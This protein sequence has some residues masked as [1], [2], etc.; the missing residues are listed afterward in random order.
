MYQWLIIGAVCYLVVYV[1][2]AIALYTIAKRE[3]YKNKWMA[4]VPVFNTYYIGVCA[5]KNKIFGAQTK[6]ISLACAIL[7]LLLISG[8][9]LNTV[10]YSLVF[11]QY[12]ADYATLKE[13]GAISYYIYED[14][15]HIPENLTWAGWICLNFENYV[16]SFM[17]LA[18]F[19]LEV[20]VVSSFFRTYGPRHYFLYTVTSILFPVLGIMMFV[21]RKNRAINYAEFL[22]KERERH[23]R[24]YQQQYGQQQNFNNPYNPYNTPNNGNMNGNPYQNPPQPKPAPQDPF[25]EFTAKNQDEKS[26][27]DFY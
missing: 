16:L 12:I 22:Y 10:A 21:V 18:Y 7:E 13:N 27:D 9:I 8:Y 5:Q 6:Y 23:Y 24:M 3:G 14:V 19:V 17:E 4:F 26:D 1:F 20:F 25:E 15:S 2:E 11:E